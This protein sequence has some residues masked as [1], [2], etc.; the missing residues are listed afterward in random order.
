[1]RMSLDSFERTAINSACRNSVFLFSAP[2]GV[3][4]ELA[5]GLKELADMCS[6]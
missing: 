1:M 4:K 2:F 5:C 6:P 3:W